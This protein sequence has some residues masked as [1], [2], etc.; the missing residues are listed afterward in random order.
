M[1]AMGWKRFVGILG[2]VDLGV[3]LGI[4]ARNETV[5]CGI[6]YACFTMAL[7]QFIDVVRT[8]E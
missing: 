6:G 2:V 3:A 8:R 4:F 7:L 1:E 5:V